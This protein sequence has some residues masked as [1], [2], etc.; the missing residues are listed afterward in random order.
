MSKSLF[1]S[2]SIVSL[3]TMISRILG[4]IRDVVAAQIYGVNA[5]VDAFN[6]AFKIPNFMRNLFA[7]GSFSQAFVPVLSQYRRT[8]SK[9]QARE[10]INHIAGCLGSILFV[11]T[12]LGVIAAPLLVTLSAPGLGPLRFHYATEMLRV[13][14]PYLMLISLT[15]FSASILNSYGNFAIPSLT[16]ALLNIVLIIAAFWGSRYF[17]VPIEAQA[18][19]VFIAGVVQ[20]LFQLPFL[21][22]KGLL[23]I[24][25][26]NWQ[27]E[28][29]RRVLRLMVPAIFGASVGQ[30][31]LFFNT[32]FASFLPV[33][34]VTWLYYS[35]R[36]AYFPLGVFG[37]ALATV[38]LPHLSRKHAEQSPTQF[39]SALDWGI[40]CNLLIG[41]PAT[42]IILIFAGP[43][44]AT[45]FQHGRFT[46]HD[47]L[48]TRQSLIA[49][50]F[51]LQAFMLVKVL[52]TGFYARQDI[53]T[54]VRIAVVTM[55]LNLIFNIMLLKPFAHAGLALATSLSSWLN[56]TFLF[57]GLRKKGV[58]HLQKGWAAFGLRLLF[59]N[60]AISFM[61]WWAEGTLQQWFVWDWQQRF[62]HLLGWL[63]L[64]VVLYLFC[65]WL[66]GMR[67]RHFNAQ[68]SSP[69]SSAIATGEKDGR[70]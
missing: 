30:V 42:C 65:L 2:T 5:S 54:P 21:W 22:R 49:Y 10:F 47:V 69:L 20:F 43:L 3:M 29:V 27:D 48:M 37:V 26:L 70:E 34:S 66:S 11:V 61:L 53:K 63:I 13:T 32:V 56:V 24:P 19:G 44:I 68:I 18:W 28:G 40:R 15:A 31:S 25:K 36:L 52:S 51:G 9:E 7:E 62:A 1:K 45:L 59:A 12:I 39:M 23:P 58:Y 67:L 4:F 14:F 55:G 50:A 64:A 60:G 16:P 35:E 57:L 33:G 41:V 46:I 6:I 17:H 8:S 38:V